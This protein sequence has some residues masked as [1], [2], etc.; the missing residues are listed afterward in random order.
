MI[1]SDFDIEINRVLTRC[2][3]IR[4]AKRPE[5]TGGAADVLL[6]FKEGATLIGSTPNV[7]WAVYFYK[8]AK[9]VAGL[10]AQAFVSGVVKSSEPPIDRWADAINYLLLAW[11]LF[12]EATAPANSNKEALTS[13]PAPA[14]PDDVDLNATLTP[15]IRKT[16]VG[17]VDPR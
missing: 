13:V 5:Y 16:S 14:R 15:H 17:A 12:V 11:A 6:N 10:M 7:V 3:A 4:E 1:Q 9:T 2:K 8:H